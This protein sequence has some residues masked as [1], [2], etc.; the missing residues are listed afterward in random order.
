MDCNGSPAALTITLCLSV[1]GGGGEVSR[2]FEP[3]RRSMGLDLGW[4]LQ[5]LHISPAGVAAIGGSC[6]RVQGLW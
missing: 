3:T 4:S 2:R 6:L 5:H 1:E